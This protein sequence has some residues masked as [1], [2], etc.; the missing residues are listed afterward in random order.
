[1]LTLP[2][3]AIFDVS[4]NDL[5]GEFPHLESESLRILDL[6]NNRLSG[7]LDDEIFGHPGVGRYTAPYLFT[8][9]KFDISHNGF[10]G[11]I[12]LSGTSGFYKPDGARHL[13]EESLQ[14][15][16]Y[17]DLGFNLFSGTI[18]NNIG[19]F[20]KLS[21]LFL[22]HNRLVGTIPKSIYRGSGNGAN[23][24]PLVQLFLQQNQLS[25]TIHEGLATLPNLR[26]IYVDGNKFTG[27]VPQAL[28]D[29]D[30]NGQFL[31]DKSAANRCD[32][33][34]CPVNSA[35]HEG[36]APCRMCPNDNGVHRYLGQHD[37]ECRDDGLNQEEI[38]DLF[39]KETHG[40]EW[41]DATYAWEIGEPACKRKG[42]ECNG[43]G[44]VTK[45]TLPSLGLRGP[46][47]PELSYLSRL[48]TLDLRHNELTGFLPSDLRF[49][50][51]ENLDIRGTH[52]DGVVRKWL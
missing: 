28:C 32:G 21:G 19:N 45:I 10:E 22:E 44:E 38:L 8:L 6:S 13:S 47:V 36:V 24:L 37:N 33:I 41:N 2:N 43:N 30:L 49:I 4:S 51:L 23:P 40:D 29:L 14:Q 7:R 52:L 48:R 17:F 46:I 31:E 42:V 16:Q 5:V 25:G 50:N 12:P 18:P 34:S 39:Y 9:V 20:Q 27:H 11:T 15:L 26:E 35:S 3:L 1:M